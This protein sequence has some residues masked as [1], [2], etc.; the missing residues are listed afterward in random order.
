[1][2]KYGK[3]I[4]VGLGWAFGGPIGAL[5][6]FAVGK[7]FDGIDVDTTHSSR[8]NN[9]ANRTQTSRNDF[10]TALL[11]L[12]AAVMKADGKIMKSELDYVKK[13]LVKNFGE[14]TATEATKILK[15]ILKKDIPLK[16]VCR[17]ICMNTQYEARTQLIHY[18]FGIAQADGHVSELEVKKIEE[19]A[20]HLNISSSDIASIKAMFYKD[21]QSAYKVLGLDNSASIAEIKK[22]YRKKAIEHHPDK[23]EHLG[24]DIR[25]GAEEK[26]RQVNEAYEQIKKERVFN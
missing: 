15:D 8:T 14:T 12:M 26:F 3:W 7:G 11:V 4:G 1:M 20:L 2:G 13:F 10:I 16:E 9:S 19:I 18:M 21:I 24:E 22:A 6:G 25:K 23:V 5:I 17:Q